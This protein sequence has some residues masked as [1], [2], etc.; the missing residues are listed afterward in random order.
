MTGV[1]VGVDSSTQS[2]K[3]LVVDADNGA[4]VCSAS[5]PHPEGS[6]VRDAYFA[7]TTALSL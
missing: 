2:C 4:T 3:V 7:S 5:A 1:V 6:A